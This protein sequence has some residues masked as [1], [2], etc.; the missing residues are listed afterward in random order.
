MD[1][2]RESGD[3]ETITILETILTYEI[4]GTSCVVECEW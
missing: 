3:P 4:G 1:S 2:A